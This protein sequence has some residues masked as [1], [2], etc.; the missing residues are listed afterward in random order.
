[1]SEAAER[2]NHNLAEFLEKGPGLRYTTKTW[3]VARDPARKMV[4]V[5]GL[6]CMGCGQMWREERPTDHEDSTYQSAPI[7]DSEQ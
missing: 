2:A 5:G 6:G 7:M 3:I 4:L 1:M